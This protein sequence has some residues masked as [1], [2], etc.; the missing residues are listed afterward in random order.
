MALVCALALVGGPIAASSVGETEAA[1]SD[2]EF[3]AGTF[4][5]VVIQPPTIATCV[6]ATLLGAV[7]TVTITWSFPAGS[8][9]TSAANVN[10]YVAEGGLLTNL[11]SLLLGSSLSTTGPVAGVYTTV[12][13]PALLGGLLGST[14]LI[15]FQTKDGSGW[16]SYLAPATVVLGPLGL[17]ATC[18]I[19]TPIPKPA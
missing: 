5:A 10:Y 19:G 12:F 13:R 11:T 6:P 9:Y 15:A 14:F 16:T 8:T 17:S 7:S 1:W 2:S 18:T 4:N 3:G